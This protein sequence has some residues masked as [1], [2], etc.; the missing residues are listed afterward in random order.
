MLP[1]RV[2]VRFLA[3]GHAGR[4]MVEPQLVD[5]WRHLPNK[6]KVNRHISTSPR[7]SPETMQRICDVR[8]RKQCCDIDLQRDCCRVPPLG[9]PPRHVISPYPALGPSLTCRGIVVEFLRPA[10]LLRV[11]CLRSVR[12]LTGIR[13]LLPINAISE[14]S[15]L[16]FMQH[17]L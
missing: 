2:L 14:T 3:V 4:L 11:T 6:T 7:T 12:I 13:T 9:D 17:L 8:D 1:R 16:T 15:H 10:M 5:W